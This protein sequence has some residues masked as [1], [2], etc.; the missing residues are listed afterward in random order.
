MLKK[1]WHLA[2]LNPLLETIFKMSITLLEL[3]IRRQMLPH[4]TLCKFTKRTNMEGSL[5]W[6]FQWN[7]LD[8]NERFKQRRNSR[9]GVSTESHNH[10]TF[11][12]L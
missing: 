12:F 2:E 9:G 8:I 6:S 1:L 10:K 4:F 3:E 7:L 5:D 11:E